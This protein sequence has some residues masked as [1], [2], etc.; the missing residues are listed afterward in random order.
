MQG[1]THLDGISFGHAYR[2]YNLTDARLKSTIYL[3]PNPI[4]SL[5]LGHE[6]ISMKMSNFSTIYGD[7]VPLSPISTHIFDNAELLPR[8]TFMVNSSIH[9][10][11]IG[12]FDLGLRTRNSKHH[13]D[14]TPNSLR[15]FIVLFAINMSAATADTPRTI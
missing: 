15:Q 9:S 14:E 5:S 2:R 3:I 7:P 13:S 11:M 4:F 1:V 6:R 8:H 12:D 10:E